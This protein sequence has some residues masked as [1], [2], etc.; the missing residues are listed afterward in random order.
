[1]LQ[2]SNSSVY[3]IGDV[4]ALP[5]K[6][7]GETRRLEHVDSARK[8]ARHAVSAIME[9][10]KTGDFDYLPFFYSRVFTLSW[11]FFGDNVGEVVYYGDFSGGT[12]G[13]YWI[14]KGHLVG[15]FL[16]GGTKEEYEAV[17]KTTRLRPAI[18]DLAE[19]ERQ[20]LGF[21]VTVSQKPMASSPP[22][23]ISSTSSLVLE[24]PL[25]AWHATAGVILA[26][27]IAAF[28]YFYGKKRR[29]W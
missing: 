16:E 6:A 1:M 29:R 11:Q 15:A 10:E 27:S 22:V 9:P 21:A 14:S 26:A 2:S 23:E 25:H 4:A 24:S 17:A 7:F 8:S 18:E 28:A 13:A 12:F 20:G 5:V 19:L 3:A